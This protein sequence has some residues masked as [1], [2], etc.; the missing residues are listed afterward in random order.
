M[1][2]YNFDLKIETER[3]TVGI[4][5]AQDYGYFERN[6]DGSGGGLWFDSAYENGVN[7]DCGLKDYDGW[8][9]LPKEVIR[10]LRDNGIM[11]DE[12]FE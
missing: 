2:Q 7:V 1:N 3:F 12:D 10:A 11:V 9:V 6:S 4:D 8:A 5:T